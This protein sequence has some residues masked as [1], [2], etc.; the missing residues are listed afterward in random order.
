MSRLSELAIL[1][2]SVSRSA[3]IAFIF[4]A[5]LIYY[6]VS[7]IPCPSDP[8]TILLPNTPEHTESFV[9][10]YKDVLLSSSTF[11]LVSQNHL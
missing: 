6:G 2:N 8:D 9:P 11:F 4:N 7:E 10:I 1:S 3:A 5:Y